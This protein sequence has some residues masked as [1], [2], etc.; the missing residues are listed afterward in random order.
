[1]GITKIIVAINKL[2]LIKEDWK[3]DDASFKAAINKILGHE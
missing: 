2:D 1:M 3:K